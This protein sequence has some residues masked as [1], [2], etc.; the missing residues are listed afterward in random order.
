[1]QALSIHFEAQNC[2]LTMMSL[3][4][5]GAVIDFVGATLIKTM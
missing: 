3:G 4:L 5:R 1:M 2:V